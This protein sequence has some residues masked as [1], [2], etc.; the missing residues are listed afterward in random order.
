MTAH[1]GMRRMIVEGAGAGQEEV[2]GSKSSIAVVVVDDLLSPSRYD[3]LFGRGRKVMEHPGNLRLLSL[4]K[5]KTPF[6]DAASKEAKTRLTVEVV[7]ILKCRLSRFLKKNASGVWEEVTDALARKKV[8][9]AFRTMR[10]SAARKQ[11]KHTTQGQATT[12]PDSGIVQDS[13]K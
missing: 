9:H 6:Y 11:E 4:V 7:Q 2:D 5:D 1:A 8:S 12:R 10:Q 3:I 13:T